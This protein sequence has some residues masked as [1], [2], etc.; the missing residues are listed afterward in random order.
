MAK[1]I[2]LKVRLDDPEGFRARLAKTAR[3][4]GPYQKTDTYF[5]GPEGSFRIRESEGKAIVCRKEKTIASGV[6]VSLETEFQVDDIFAFRRFSLS[7]GYREWYRKEKTGE[8][9]K[10]GDILIE[11]GTVSDL[12]YFAELELLLDETSPADLVSSAQKILLDALDS[13]GVPRNRIEPRTYSELLG[14]RGK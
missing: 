11:E 6:E 1:E 14:H 8:A 10:W 5:R 4:E 7:L 12:G 2:E 3:Q 9:W 13:L